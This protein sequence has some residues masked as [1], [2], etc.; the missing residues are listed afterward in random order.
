MWFTFERQES[1]IKMFSNKISLNCLQV[2]PKHFF[3]S[4][5]RK[6]VLDSKFSLSLL[7]FQWLALWILG[8]QLSFHRQHRKNTWYKVK[9]KVL[10]AQLGQTLCDPM[11]CSP[12][13]SFVYGIFQARILEWFA[14][15]FSRGSSPPRD[16]T[17]VCTAGRFF[18]DWA[19]REVTWYEVVHKNMD[20]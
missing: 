16:Q 12:L 5:K 6:R 2:E 19:T 13:G 4:D 7:F 15:L 14:I 11:D 9:G 17:Q 18:T 8:K 10:V 1:S 3:F 20:D